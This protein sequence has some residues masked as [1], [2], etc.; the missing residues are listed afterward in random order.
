ML[1]SPAAFREQL[2]GQRRTPPY[3]L[4]GAALRPLDAPLLGRDAQLIVFD[5]QHNLISDLDAKCLPKRRRD[6]DTAVL[7]H[8]RPGF[9]C[10][11]TL[12]LE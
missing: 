1:G 10:H 7:V 6:H 2:V 5:P 8:A 3:V 9:F 4:P 11:G 12:R